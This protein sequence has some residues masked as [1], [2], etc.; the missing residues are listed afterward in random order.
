M[1]SFTR[2]RSAVRFT[3]LFSLFAAFL[4]ATSVQATLVL[5]T[6]DQ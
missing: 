6:I 4:I 1:F 2:I 5:Q 3:C